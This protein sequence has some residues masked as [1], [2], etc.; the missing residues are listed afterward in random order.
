[1]NETVDIT[2]KI[3]LVLREEF[4]ALV[5]KKHK[6]IREVLPEIIQQWINKNK[7]R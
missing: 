4:K 1:M 2:C 6:T 7:G 5:L 3:E